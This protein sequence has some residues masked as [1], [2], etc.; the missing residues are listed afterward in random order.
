MDDEPFGKYWWIFAILSAIVA[1]GLVIW[2]LPSIRASISALRPPAPAKRARRVEPESE[3]E[4]E[5][6]DGEIGEARL[7]AHLAPERARV[8]EVECDEAESAEPPKP[9]LPPVVA[10]APPKKR[11]RKRAA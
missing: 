5:S 1:V 9:P 4:S 3:Y 10:V 6:D 2:R 7:L 11:G 8:E